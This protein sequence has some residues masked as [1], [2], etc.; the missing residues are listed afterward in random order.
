MNTQV[1]LDFVIAS[2]LHLTRPTY[3][4]EKYDA[5]FC[6]SIGELTEINRVEKWNKRKANNVKDEMRWTLDRSRKKQKQLNV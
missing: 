6:K 1:R 3:Q 4:S 2:L 5:V